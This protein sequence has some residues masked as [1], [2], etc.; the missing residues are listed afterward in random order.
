MPKLKG[1]TQKEL[2][3]E[4]GAR[5]YLISYLTVTERLPLL[6]RAKGKGDNHIFHPGSIEVV[7]N[8]LKRNKIEILRDLNE[9]N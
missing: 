8:W 4:T 5:H 7:N 1:L 2:R 6:H 3:A 9:R